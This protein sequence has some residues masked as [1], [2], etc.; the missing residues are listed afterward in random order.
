MAAGLVTINFL[1][2]AGATK[3]GR[4]W[5][6]DGTTAGLLY[7]APVLVDGSGNVIDFTTASPV[8]QSG[9]WTVQIG[10][11][12]N[13]TAIL[14]TVAG[15]TASGASLTANP[16]TAGA[17]ASTTNPTAVTDGQVVNLRADKT[18]RLVNAPFQVRDLMTRSAVITLTNTT[19][20]T[21]IA[22]VAS[23]F[24]DMVSIKLC[25]TSATA[26]RCDIRDDTGGTVQDTWYIPAGQTVGEVFSA[27]FKQTAVNKNW[28]V[29]LSGSV[30]D[31]RIVAQFAQNL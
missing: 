8:T 15:P 2:G 7:P 19:E 25:N 21:L 20:T 1:D 31:V 18:G 24:L 22:A 16:L 28:T 4:F 13:T 9:T 11:T 26:V 30:T 14:A 10:N 5:S 6:S 12:P 23:T 27:P 3:T 17:R 29:Q